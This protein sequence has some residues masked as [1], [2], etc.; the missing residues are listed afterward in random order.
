VPSAKSTGDQLTVVQITLVPVPM[1]MLR[2]CAMSGPTK[3]GRAFVTV[4]EVPTDYK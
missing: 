1:A 2:D 3:C 4:P